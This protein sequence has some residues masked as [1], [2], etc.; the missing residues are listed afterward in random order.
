MKLSQ[1]ISASNAAGIKAPKRTHSMLVYGMPK[2]GKT[3]LAATIAKL[4]A[5]D[6]V[7]W[8][9][10]ENGADTILD[11]YRRGRLTL[12]QLDKIT[13]I[14]VPDTRENPTGMETLLRA[15]ATRNP[16]KICEEHGKVA[17]PQ[18]AKDGSP[19]IDFC[20]SKLTD[21]DVIV[22]DS[23]S[24]AGVSALNMAM[25]GKAQEAKAEWDHYG[26]QGR[27]LSDL[28]TVI[29]AAQYTN[30]ICITHVQVLEDDAGKDVYSPMCGTKTFSAG[31][32]K[33][34]GS[35]IYAEM[36][37]KK[38]KAGSSTSYNAMTQAGSRIG[39]VLEKEDELDLSIAL[40]KAGLFTQSSGA[41]TEA[42]STDAQAVQSTAVRQESEVV[43][44]NS[45]TV[46]ENR[47][48]RFG[49]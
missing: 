44:K 34:F 1:L 48:K 14:K 27:F 35:I 2:V 49:K 9:D 22:I 46:V 43:E 15:I 17:C 40:P 10:L 11:M 12:E 16:V 36:K 6:N 29:Q 19:V 21:R 32:A 42:V 3:E 18:C 37:M 41:D 33:Y 13:L 25:I 31:V 45:S 24:Q 26:M 39:I 5:V 38:H 30:F 7:Y 23:L 20:H 4:N 47:P 8:F 28:L